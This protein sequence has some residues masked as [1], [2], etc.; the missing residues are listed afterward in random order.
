MLEDTRIIKGLPLKNIIVII[1]LILLTVTWSVFTGIIFLKVDRYPFWSEFKN[2]LLNKEG[3]NNRIADL[4]D[5]YHAYARSIRRRH[6]PE[7]I[8]FDGNK[9]DQYFMHGRNYELSGQIEI[10]KR[11]KYFMRIK[12]QELYRLYINDNF[13][14]FN[15]V[16]DYNKTFGTNRE[17]KKDFPVIEITKFLQLGLN[18][19]RVLANFSFE[20]PGRNYISFDIMDE[21]RRVVFS[22][23]EDLPLIPEKT[24]YKSISLWLFILS[25]LYLVAFKNKHIISHEKVI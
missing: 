5:S 8:V 11:D 24:F 9:V 20:K 6:Y 14:E 16:P 17:Y 21:D 12:T 2:I 1:T 18:E 22:E 25:F 7:N 19:V 3:D 23:K 4:Y 10:D 15:W 13:V